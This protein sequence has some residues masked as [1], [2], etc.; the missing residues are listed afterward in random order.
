VKSFDFQWE[1]KGT[2]LLAKNNFNVVTERIPNRLTTC[3]QLSFDESLYVLDRSLEGYNFL[4]R[5]LG[6]FDINSHM[7]GF[8]PEG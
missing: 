7:I 5:N 4:Y 6:P 2:A 8:T 3:P 1:A